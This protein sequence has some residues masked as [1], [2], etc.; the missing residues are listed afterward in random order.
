M[1]LAYFH[2][3]EIESVEGVYIKYLNFVPI[4]SRVT[5]VLWIKQFVCLGRFI[6]N[7]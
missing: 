5:R 1:G 3:K 2:D 7:D 4:F 6:R